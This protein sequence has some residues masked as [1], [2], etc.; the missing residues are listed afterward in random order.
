V[1]T[2]TGTITMADVNVELGFS[3]TAQ[4]SLNNADVRALAGIPSG[5]ISMNDLR[6]KPSLLPYLSVVNSTAI[7]V[8]I[9]AYSWS[10]SGFG[11]RYTNPTQPTSAA[12]KTRFAKSTSSILYTTS[13]S[14]FGY[15]NGFPW[16]SSGFGTK[17][18]NPVGAVGGAGNDL[19]FNKAENVVAYSSTSTPY[20]SAYPWS[21][22][23]FGTRF[24]SPATTPTGTGY[25]VTFCVD[26]NVLV[27]GHSTSPYITAYAWS[28][29]TGFGSKYADPSVLPSAR[30]WGMSSYDRK[31]LGVAYDA[32]VAVARF[33]TSIPV[34]VYGIDTAGW[35][36][37]YSG[38]A[39][40]P[41]PYGSDAKFAVNAG[42]SGY[43]AVS[44]SSYTS[45]NSSPYIQVYAWTDNLGYGTKYS[46]PATL[47]T[48]SVA[49]VSWN[50]QTALITAHTNSPYVT[51]YPWSSS[52]FGTKYSDPS[53]SV[54]ATGNGVEFF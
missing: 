36:G 38:P 6:G 2:P 10:S 42:Y 51:A 48:G 49:D 39:S 33:N 46:N 3:S 43:L 34:V 29:S 44:S 21:S 32:R 25:G 20:I 54:G 28:N 7:T 12:D 14:T 11:S 52:G 35:Q 50:N 5:T 24:T 16:S 18:T 27:V 47:P 19:A 45:P 37:T 23:G 13:T 17:Y 9:G 4:I 40:Y 8:R 30:G 22:S 31:S 15:I 26:D 41:A 1:T 53:T